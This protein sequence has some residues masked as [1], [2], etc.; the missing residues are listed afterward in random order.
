MKSIA[1]GRHENRITKMTSA[2]TQ[3]S[4]LRG[5]EDG[6][7]ITVAICT[8]NRAAFLEL[9]VRSV[10]EQIHDDTELM[11]LDNVSTDQTAEL[12]RRFMSGHPNVRYVYEARTGLSRARNTAVLHARGQYVI[13][14]DD[15]AT[16]DPG[17]LAAYQRFFSHPPS[18]KIAVAG[19]AVFPK[20]QVPPPAWL[21]PKDNRFDMGDKPF[22]FNRQDSPWETNC[23]FSRRL[24][25][26]QGSFDVR[27]GHI[28][29]NLGSHEGADL[30]L[31][32]QDAGYEIWWL[33]G[34]GIRH[35]IHADRVNLRCSC[36]GAFAAGA[37]SALKRLKFAGSP[38]RRAALR[39]GRLA[40]A[41]FQFLINL[42]V[43]L[44]LFPIG[45]PAAAG[46]ALRRACR[47]A[48]FAWQL[49]KPI[50]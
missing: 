43:C 26:E 15:D 5:G 47:A 49:L 50:S 34:A 28:G 44:L 31:R 9:A 37:A 22:C 41:P 12:A 29:T 16:A 17:W 24:T 8:H 23:A 32:L 14:L 30:N 13:F 20:Y 7:L 3:V 25:L 48:G 40:V 46:G 19:G 6:P 21:S 10:L 4:A 18:S 35:T 36:R 38:G 2:S 1:F 33:P 39:L 42:G 11:I 27:L 45:K